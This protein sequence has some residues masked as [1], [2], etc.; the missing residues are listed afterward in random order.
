MTLGFDMVT[1]LNQAKPKN[2]V[3]EPI[4]PQS[5][6]KQ[7][8]GPMSWQDV[9]DVMEEAGVEKGIA[10]QIFSLFGAGVQIAEEKDKQ[11]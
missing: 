7:V 11:R 6:A 8:I 5:L 3:G 9:F 1:Y 4:T 10:Y 2:I